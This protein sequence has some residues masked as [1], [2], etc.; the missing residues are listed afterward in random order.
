MKLISIG[1]NVQIQDGVKFLNYRPSAEHFDKL[2]DAGKNQ[3]L[4]D[5][6]AIIIEDN[7]FI[8]KDVLILPNPDKPE[9]FCISSTFQLQ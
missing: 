8:G 6:G 7:V 4:R 3:M 9:K 1:S 2:F 5:L